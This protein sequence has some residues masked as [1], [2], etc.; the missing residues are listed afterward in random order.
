MF[1][2]F[3][4]PSWT[5]GCQE[6]HNSDNKFM[7]RALFMIKF[8]VVSYGVKEGKVQSTMMIQTY[9]K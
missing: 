3:Q 7:Y 9:E 2:N 4:K 1:F 8:K 5:G 6:G